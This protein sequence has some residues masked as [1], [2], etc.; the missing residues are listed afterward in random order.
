MSGIGEG[1]LV[2]QEETGIHRIYLPLYANHH[3]DVQTL[4]ISLRSLIQLWS[5]GYLNIMGCELF[6]LFFIP[7]TSL[8]FL[9]SE[10]WW[11][12]PLRYLLER[13]ELGVSGF[14]I[15][16]VFYN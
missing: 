11:H 3:L 9:G 16:S 15:L 8:N 2:I 13:V 6:F 4:H 12:Y 10:R 5:Y 14:R 1:A 7:G